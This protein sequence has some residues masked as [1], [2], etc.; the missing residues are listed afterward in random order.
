MA[1]GSGEKPQ[2]VRHY[3]PMSDETPAPPI[4]PAPQTASAPAMPAGEPHS[5]F[6]RGLRWF[7]AELLV[8]VAGILI[9]MSLNAWY[10]DRI[11]ARSE[12]QYLTLLARDLASM[13]QFLDETVAFEELQT[14]DALL[15]YR[16]LSA[17]RLPPDTLPLSNAVEHLG[18]RRTLLLKSGTYDD[19][20]ST[21]N[22]HLI[23]NA[24]LRDQIAEYYQ[25]TNLRFEVINKNNAFFVD[26]SFNARLLQSGLVQSRLS[27]N[28]PQLQ[29]SNA[30]I[31][32][33]LAGGYVDRPRDLLWTL[34]PDAREWSMVRSIVVSRLQVAQLS[35]FYGRERAAAA[36]TLKAAIDAELAR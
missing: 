4:P 28:L 35:A 8:V 25:E 15:L 21:G 12:R 24:R 31:M 33:E 6:R 19:L 3:E 32:K 2:G 20:V 7:L 22:F 26:E 10:Q 14:R 17:P 36:R 11:D 1:S 5:P 9:A 16:A 18:G 23:R 34:P 27:S 29:S 13:G 30:P